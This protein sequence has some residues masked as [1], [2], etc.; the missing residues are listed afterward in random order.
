[1]R[2]GGVRR[3]GGKAHRGTGHWAGVAGSMMDDIRRL[4]DVLGPSAKQT[5]E[6]LP[7]SNVF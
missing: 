7:P 6:N 3:V 2:I 1:M 4:E 5:D